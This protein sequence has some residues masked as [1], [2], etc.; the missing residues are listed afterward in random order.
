MTARLNVPCESC[1]ADAGVMCDPDCPVLAVQTALN[2]Y[3][4][5][6]PLPGCSVRVLI[7][8]LRATPSR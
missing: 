5:R 8:E 4:P 6:T 7:D 3:T 2:T 1:G